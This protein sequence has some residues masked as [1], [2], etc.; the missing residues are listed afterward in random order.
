MKHLWVLPAAASAA[1]SAYTVSVMISEGPFGFLTEH[2]RNGW[3]VQI[4]VDLVCAAI[5]ALCF[6]VPAARRHG[7]AP[8]PWVLATVPLGSPALLAFTA[9]IPRPRAWS[10]RP[11]LP[12]RRHLRRARRAAPQQQGRA[13][14]R[15]PPDPGAAADRAVHDPHAI[16]LE[17]Q[18]GDA[19]FDEEVYIET[20]GQADDVR[21]ILAD[22]GVRDA[23][24]EIVTARIE[25]LTI[26]GDASES[27]L[28]PGPNSVCVDLPPGV[29][30]PCTCGRSSVT[31]GAASRSRPSPSPRAERCAVTRPM[32]FRLHR[33][34]GATRPEHGVARRTE[35]GEP[36]EQRERGGL[37]V[38]LTGRVGRAIGTSVSPQVLASYSQSALPRGARPDARP[39]HRA[40]ELVS[41]SASRGAPGGA[42][43]RRPA[44]SSPPRRRPGEGPR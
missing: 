38:L 10:R 4:G 43:R 11:A 36:I 22:A 12:A 15:V 19:G 41:R 21:R 31:R 25:S 39:H 34:R 27:V 37:R 14:G 1:F 13:H 17:L 26:G 23:V 8:L 9:R 42:P 7:V 18:L 35:T 33:V 32:S 30:A 6:A 28:L 40:K 2:S 5:V 3:G 16:N 29:A 44:R 20:D 24:R